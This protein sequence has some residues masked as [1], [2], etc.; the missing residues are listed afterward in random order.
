VWLFTSFLGVNVTKKLTQ[1]VDSALY[2]EPFFLSINTTTC[3]S[4]ACS[5][6]KELFKIKNPYLKL[7]LLDVGEADLERSV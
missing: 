2:F 3:S 6:K 1:A 7:C 4:L 5:R